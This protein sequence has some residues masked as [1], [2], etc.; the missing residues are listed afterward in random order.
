MKRRRAVA[1]VIL[2][3]HQGTRRQNLE[4]RGRVA[5]AAA[6]WHG[7]GDRAVPIHFLAA[8][9]HGPARVRDGAVVR[10]LLTEQYGVPADAVS[11][12]RWSLC[13]VAEIRGVRALARLR[14]FDRV[15]A[16]THGYH[17][18]SP[19][20]PPPVRS[21]RTR[22]ALARPAAPLLSAGRRGLHALR[23]WLCPIAASTMRP[24]PRLARTGP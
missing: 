17:V 8:D 10:A 2:G 9:T 12:R 20:L 18:R 15:L 24:W 1:V 3:K 5:L 19:P 21:S 4:L 16:I 13:T 6:V 14:R 23:G 22:R 7:L 11:V